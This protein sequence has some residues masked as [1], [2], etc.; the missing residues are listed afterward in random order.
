MTQ[1]YAHLADGAVRQ[2][3]AATAGLGYGEEGE[4][5]NLARHEGFEPSTF[6]SGGRRSIQL[7]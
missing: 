6:G 2:A 3:A 5:R 7:S 4:V 1:R